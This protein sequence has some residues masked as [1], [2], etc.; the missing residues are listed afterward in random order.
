VSAKNVPENFGPGRLRGLNSYIW[1]LPLI[2]FFF[3]WEAT[4]RLGMLSQSK[5]PL[6]SKVVSA[7]LLGLTSESFVFFV[8]QSFINLTFGILLAV[9]AALPLAL[10]AG[11]KVKFDSAFTPAI[12]LVG[13]LPDLALLPILVMWIGPGNVAA[14]TMAAVC[15]FFPLFFTL[16]EGTKSIPEEFF[17]VSTVFRSGKIDMLHKMIFPA[18]LPNMISGL[19]ISFDFVW[20]VVLAIELIASVSGIGTFIN[21]SIGSGSLES[22]FAGIMAIGIIAL[23]VDRIVLATLESRIRRWQG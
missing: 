19:R 20:E 1:V 10:F 13:A 18:I 17:H 5:I 21:S 2:M 8:F 23:S 15:A 12:M 22:A 14:V 16:R 6:F 3:A 11:L 4:V 9:L 7:F